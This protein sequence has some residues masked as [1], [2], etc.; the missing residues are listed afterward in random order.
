MAHEPLHTALHHLRRLIDAPEAGVSDAQLVE[1]FVST[2]DEAAFELLVRR[3]ERLVLNVCRRVLHDPHDAADAFQATFLVLVRKA[4]A[5]GKRG[6]VAGWLYKV[7]YRVALRARTGAA[8]RA[9]HEQLGRDLAALPAPETPDAAW[10]E[11][12][13]LLDQEVSRLPEKYRVPVVLC[14]LESRT[15]EEAARQL[16]C[17]RGTVSTRLTRARELLRRRLARRGL[18]L[19]AALLATLLIE[20]AASGAAPVGLADA[21]VRIARGVAAGRAAAGLVSAKVVS[22][23]EGA[24]H[25]MFATKLKV[26]TSVLLAVAVVGAGAG[27]LTYHTYAAGPSDGAAVPAQ[28]Q[29]GGNSG[30]N[31]FEAADNPGQRLLTAGRDPVAETEW[32]ERLVLTPQGDRVLSVT[33]SPDGRMLANASLNGVA[34][35]WDLASGK[36]IREVHPR[37]DVKLLSAAFS[38]DGSVLATGGG[39]PGKA[40][41]VRLWDARTG[42]EEVAL[43]GHVDVVHA[44]AWAPDGHLLVSGSQDGTIRLWNIA[45]ARAQETLKGA[46]QNVFAVAFSPDGKRLATAGGDAAAG[47]DGKTGEVRLWDVASGKILAVIHGHVGTAPSVAFSPDGKVLASPGAD[48]TVRLWDATTG[49]EVRR[50]AS[51]LAL[52]RQV[53]FSPDGRLLA[54]GAG[55]GPVTIWEVATGKQLATL[56]GSVEGEVGSVAFSPDGRYLAVGGGNGK[57][58]YVILW[59]RVAKATPRVTAAMS[60][61]RPA[62]DG[63]A[64]DRLEQLLQEMLRSQRGDEQVLDALFLA[65]LGRYPTD[66]ERKFGLESVGKARD[67]TEAFG[68]VLGVLTSSREFR[69]HVEALEKRLPASRN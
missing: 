4:A 1:R 29:Q 44:V 25:A 31:P 24:L 41:D 14:Y 28:G 6:S 52:I 53:A 36:V 13:P 62:R 58:G 43:R 19:S 60:G 11:L 56:R 5:I 2:R 64:G 48:R 42:K 3:H 8:N 69:S 38:P 9:A 61:A 66:T 40:G 17:S 15:Y 26:L 59:E 23:T 32:R 12:R 55:D 10:R 27:I 68:N 20:R 30:T 57:G 22:L 18:T 65:T 45:E 39:E 63:V 16:G 34:T 47:A 54:M 49:M 35:L 37:A 51:P 33:F 50:L 7:A 46:G 21:A 67:R